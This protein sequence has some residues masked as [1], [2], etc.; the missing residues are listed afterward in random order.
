MHGLT[1]PINEQVKQRI[2]SASAAQISGILR[3]QNRYMESMVKT[4]RGHIKLL[5]SINFYYSLC[6]KGQ[7]IT[8]TLVHT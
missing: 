8:T 3:S 5:Q 4:L 6:S 7:Q 2:Q 1:L